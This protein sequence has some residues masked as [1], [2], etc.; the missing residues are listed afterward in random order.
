MTE[1]KSLLTFDP[2]RTPEQRAYVEARTSILH[3]IG[4]Q[5]WV[6][7]TQ[8]QADRFA[9]QGILV[10]FYPEADLLVMPAAF[11]DPLQGTVQLPSNLGA[12]PPGGDASAYYLVQF[13]A[14]VENSWIADVEEAGGIYIQDHP[15]QAVVFRLT[16]AQ[17]SQ[18]GAM[19]AVRWVGLYHPAYALSYILA[20]REEPYSAT[21]LRNLA[22]DPAMLAPEDT[23]TLE[24]TFFADVTPAGM[25]TAVE[26]LGISVLH[27][28]GYNLVINA[29]VEQALALARL[30]GVFAIERHIPAT[31]GNQRA[32]IITTVNQ[33]RDLGNTTFLTNLDGTGETVGVIDSG[34]DGG[35]GGGAPAL[36]ADLAGRINVL[37]LY[38]LPLVP[39][40]TQDLAPHGTHVAG[41]IAGNGA[42]TA[43]FGGPPPPNPTTVRGMAPNA[44]IVL[45]AVWNM[46]PPFGLILDFRGF[47]NG[48]IAAH[49]NGARIH[50]N[51]WGRVGLPGNPA[52]VTGNT[53]DNNVSA[54]ID[55]FA[56]VNPEDLVVFL[57]HNQE[58]DNNGNGILDQVRLPRESVTK[59]ALTVGA[60]ENETN[61]EGLNNTYN[62]TFPG[63]FAAVPGSGPPPVAGNFPISDSANDLAMF[64]NRGRVFSAGVPL[65]RRRVKPDIVAPG[66][67][68]LSAGPSTLLPFAAGDLRRPVT[69]PPN[70]YFLSSGTSMATPVVAGAAALTRQFYRQVFAQL[71]RPAQLEAVSGFINR[72]STA[73]HADG[74]VAA[75][76]RQDAGAGQ[77][78]IVAARYNRSLDLQGN[79]TQLQA[80][81]GPSPVPQI[82]RHGTNTLLL[83]R[84]ADNS[85]RLSCYDNNLAPVAAFGTNGVV[86]IAPASRPEDDRRPAMRVHQDEVAVVWVQNG[87][88]TLN[89]Q[90]FSA[91]NG[92]E[93]D[94]NPIAIGSATRTSEFPYLV[95]NG[96]HYAVVWVHQQGGEDRV[97]FRRV[98]STGAL[99]DPNPLVVHHQAAALAEVRI[100]WNNDNNLFLVVWV[101]SRTRASG[102][103]F[104][105]LLFADGAG[106]LTPSEVLAVPA[107][108]QIRHPLILRHPENGFVL[109]WEDNTQPGTGGAG[110]FDVYMMLLNIAGLPDG[111]IN[112]NRLR[113]SD[114][115]QN[116]AGFSCYADGQAITPVW[117][118]ND[119]IN[120]DVLG[121]YAVNLTKE[122]A[123]GAQV[124]PNTPLIQNG[125]YVNHLMHEQDDVNLDSVAMTWAGGEYYLLREEPAGPGSELRLVH[126]NSDGLPDT[127]FGPGGARTISSDLSFSGVNLYWALSNLVVCYS[128]V[129]F[130]NILLLDNAGNRVNTFADNGEFSLLEII[131]E[132]V[133]PHVGHRGSGAG[134][135]IIAAWATPT[136]PQHTLRYTVLDRLGGN[137]VAVRN[138]GAAGGIL[139]DGTARRGW[140]HFVESDAPSR[141]IAAWHRTDPGPGTMA[142]FINRFTILGDR[143][144]AADIRLTALPGDSQNA[145]IAPRPVLFQPPVPVTP[146]STL[147]ARRREYGVAW[148]YRPAAGA[149]WQIRFSRLD[150]QG[151]VIAPN[152]VQV[153]S[154][155]NHATD[156]QLVW[157]RDGYG[158]A[159]LDQAPGGGPHRLFFTV[160]D[161]NG[162]VVDLRLPGAA[163]ALPAAMHQVSADGAD[164]QEYQL[165]WNGRSFHMTWTEVAGG[166]LRHMHTALFVPNQPG[167]TNTFRQPYNHPSAALL[168]ATLINGATNIRNTNLP[169]IGNN[170]ND[171]YGWGRLNL[172]QSLAPMPPVSFYVRDDGAVASGGN[173]RYRFHLPGS[174]VFLRVTLSWNDP[175]GVNLVNNLNLRMTAPDGRVFVGN[176]WGA[177]GTPNAPFSDPLPA[178]A[179]ANPFENVHNTEQIVVQGAPTL[180]GGD[181]LVEVLGGAIPI[182]DF[183]QHPG[184]PF[185]LV[186]VGSG[187]EVRYGG[188]PGGP[189]PV[190]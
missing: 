74:S 128:S 73:P 21:E 77:N 103:I 133:P 36:H 150:R 164:V 79:I 52:F 166:K 26:A 44:Q 179:P 118:S 171:G 25:Q 23:G 18:A 69:A 182:A 42:N 149:N 176:R 153:I 66:T 144:H 139:V 152:D 91:L 12:A 50:S 125:R 141:S 106:L 190:Y 10:Q 107:G 134:F 62:A 29:T 108:S 127:A 64:S 49:T 13:I 104:S 116:T 173:V 185:A 5:A 119:E 132:T 22:L 110:T 83:H 90:R 38:G 151:N 1:T 109:L 94:A 65:A 8:D 92:V 154:G 145:A 75:W 161:P 188:L 37:N 129:V 40:N 55:R 87:G 126:T 169:N 4:G 135:R 157:H 99:P 159:W 16:S 131:S 114:T 140:F 175:P 111:R 86:T 54:V 58:R 189:L 165:T 68:I 88:D 67:N 30:E 181:Y 102:Q 95:H 138:L 177:A 9:A 142:V 72:P 113:I 51:S 120:S 186:F 98:S 155:A 130:V 48:F 136:P 147:N 180:P 123:F 7:I 47:L 187:A 61:L 112:G 156:P 56:F 59:N 100:L 24:V 158:L 167:Q 163:A 93:V 82:A 115:P 89:F 27:D 178:V 78:H 97:L 71:R 160:I 20:G 101:D 148:Q 63:M 122:G 43:A 80:N 33:V 19:Q 143:Q 31:L 170:P 85:L 96:T 34:F 137:V 121:V 35:V 146:L 17:V 15:V 168:R 39:A 183:Q 105:H 124:D 6:S 57:T 2:A 174:T 70:F 32:G 76:V 3:E 172:R 60:C 46:V 81:A 184:Q 117:Q 28:T 84:G 14:P 41:T 45:H 162:A 53:Y 11:F